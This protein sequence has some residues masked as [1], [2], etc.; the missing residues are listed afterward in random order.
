MVTN[1]KLR[2]LRRR[3]HEIEQKAFRVGRCSGKTRHHTAVTLPMLEREAAKI[4]A[5]IAEEERNGTTDGT[6]GGGG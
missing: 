4:Q 6:I 2:R 5:A 1:P 3:L